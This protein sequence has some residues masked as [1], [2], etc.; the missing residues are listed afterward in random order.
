MTLHDEVRRGTRPE[1]LR[2]CTSPKGHTRPRAHPFYIGYLGETA[3]RPG[4]INARVDEN[5]HVPAPGSGRT[6]WPV[7]PRMYAPVHTTARQCSYSQWRPSIRPGRFGEI[8]LMHTRE[9]HFLL[10]GW[11]TE[12]S[13]RLSHHRRK[14]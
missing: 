9:Y 6:A 10:L 11:M 5:T 1:P 4:Q 2:T 3:A 13:E 7:D 8:T 12:L 14:A